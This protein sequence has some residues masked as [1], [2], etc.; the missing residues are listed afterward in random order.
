MQAPA[1]RLALLDALKGIAAQL[2]VLHHLAFYGPMSDL[3]ANLMPGL[4]SWLFDYARIAVQAFLVMAG[5]L[6]ARALAPEGVWQGGQPLSLLLRRYLSLALPFVAAL[7]IAIAGAALARLWMTHDSIP[8]APTLGQFLAHVLLVHTILGVD[9][10]SAGVW[11]IAIDFQLFVLLTLLLWLAR[12]FGI[13]Q[14][15]SL[16]LVA[17]L[18]A[19]SLFFFNRDA[20]WD[21]WGIY[22]FGAYAL[23]ALSYWLA[24][25]ASALWIWGLLVIGLLALLLDFRL[26]IAVALTVAL[27]LALAERCRW[28]KH[29]QGAIWAWLGQISYAVFLIHFPVCLL[30]NAAFSRLAPDSPSLNLLGMGLAW[31]LSLT[32]GHAFHHGLENPLRR[33]GTRR[34]A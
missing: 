3:A 10:L 8:A 2:I 9:S 24:R 1:P 21:S 27:L 15:G 23:G 25:Q 32:A 33:W 17:A 34:F 7:L 18:G 28:M 29:P 12:H 4:M 30:V 20:G 16:V 26:R 11:Y 31:V 19:A 14:R 22:F 13:G 6:A 5:Y